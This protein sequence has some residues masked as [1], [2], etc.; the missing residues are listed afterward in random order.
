[1]GTEGNQRLLG[2][3]I[4]YYP[5]VVFPDLEWLSPHIFWDTPCPVVI[6]GDLREELDPTVKLFKHIKNRAMLT[7]SFA[8][9]GDQHAINKVLLSVLRLLGNQREIEL[10][11]SKT[12]KTQLLCCENSNSETNCLKL[13]ELRIFGRKHLELWS[14]WTWSFKG[15]NIDIIAH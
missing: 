12:G 7:L 13:P 6:S 11:R 14:P 5:L 8:L 3:W 15:Q 10:A 1:M 4:Y 9:F 2:M